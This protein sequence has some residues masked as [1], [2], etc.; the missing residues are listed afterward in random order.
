MPTTTFTVV[1][2][3]DPADR[4][5]LTRIT[6]EIETRSMDGAS[7]HRGLSTLLDEQGQ[8]SIRAIGADRYRDTLT[9]KTYKA[10]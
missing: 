10:V 2:E 8:P 1:C 6:P 5:T 3:T 9:G 7:R 4:R